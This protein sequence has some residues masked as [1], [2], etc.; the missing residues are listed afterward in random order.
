M[1]ADPLLAWRKSFPILGRCAYLLTHSLGAMHES[2]PA[3]LTEFT[4]LWQER[5]ACAWEEAWLPRVRQT[6]DAI[7][8]LLG[9]PAGSVTLHQN[10][11][12]LLGIVASCLT[13]PPERNRV[14]F[15][16][17]D[18]S[19]L[20]Y[21]WTGQERFGAAPVPVGSRDGIG[22]ETADM[23]AAIDERTRLVALSHVLFKSSYLMDVPAIVR[24]AREVGALVLLDVYQSAGT[25]PLDLGALGVDFAVGGAVKWLCGGPG[26]CYLYVKPDLSATL[27]PAQ[28]GWFSHARPFA[29]EE[30]FS[31]AEGA[32]RFMGGSPGVPALYSCRPGLE[33]VRSVGV[34]RI[35]RKSLRQ[36]ER[37][38]RRAKEHG[39][40]V[41]T[42]LDPERRGGTVTIACPDGDRVT[43]EMIEAGV[44]VDHR[45]GAGIRIGPHFYTMDA[46]C[47][48]AV[49]EVARRSGRGT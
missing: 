23:I 20:R 40:A 3:S 12:S 33:A 44:M 19:T 34:D 18:F 47:D 13:Y 42:P 8:G 30:G 45:P 31:Y 37:I 16:S 39:L 22:I 14:V 21:V 5:G 2:V 11:T 38:I 26:A 46:E 32:S 24:R 27:E 43:R 1:D 36:T 41:R 49:D 28:R 17:P 29:F 7:G 48:R 35:R 15:P 10:V 9:A 4:G 25:V 6:A